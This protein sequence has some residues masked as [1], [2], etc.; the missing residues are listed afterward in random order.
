[1][2]TRITH[3]QI[4]TRIYVL[5]CSNY[6][7]AFSGQKNVPRPQGR[8]FDSYQKNHSCKIFVSQR[9]RLYS[10]II[11]QLRLLILFG[12]AILHIL[13]WK[14]IFLLKSLCFLLGKNVFGV[15]FSVNVQRS[16][17]SLPKTILSAINHLRQ[18]GTYYFFG[19]AT[20]FATNR[21]TK[22]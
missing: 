8:R 11:Y 2:T 12:V 7:A 3:Q 18:S 17:H 10:T 14:L 13:C 22:M 16:G 15:P 21:F 6:F 4:Y 19:T 5:F 1:M 20:R 9:S